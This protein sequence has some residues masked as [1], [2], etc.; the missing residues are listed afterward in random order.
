[1][2][3]D[4]SLDELLS[5]TRCVRRR[6]ELTRPVEREVLEECLLLAQQ[7][8]TSSC[9]SQV[10]NPVSASQCPAVD[11]PF[12]TREV[13]GSIPAAPIHTR[14]AMRVWLNHGVRCVRDVRCVRRGAPTGAPTRQRRSGY[15]E[16]GHWQADRVSRGCHR[17]PA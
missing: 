17:H 8:P 12:H 2:I 7:A 5:T 4:L 16:S 10:N 3:L 11:R 14:V 6:L 9:S 13:A 1:M 15:Q